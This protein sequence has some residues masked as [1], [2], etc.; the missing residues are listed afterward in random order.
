MDGSALIGFSHN[1]PQLRRA[2]QRAPAEVMRDVD[3]NLGRGAREVSRTARDLA[4][5]ATSLLT[6]SIQTGRLSLSEHTVS[7]LAGYAG[8]VEQGRRPGAMPPLQDLIDWIRTRRIQPA[9]PGVKTQ[10]DLAFVIGR[11]I[12]REGTAAQP[13]MEP[14]LERNESTLQRLMV[15]AAESGMTRAMA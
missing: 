12:A 11:K 1:I 8:P 10:R 3:R 15:Q 2:L 9:G 14:A 6:Q 4:P 5:K 13:F 7:A